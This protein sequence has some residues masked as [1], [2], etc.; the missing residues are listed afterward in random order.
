MPLKSISGTFFTSFVYNGIMMS[1]K[2]CGLDHIPLKNSNFSLLK[3]EYPKEFSCKMLPNN[4]PNMS[5]YS[6][7]S[8]L[9][10]IKTLEFA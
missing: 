9:N 2:L 7:V 4:S 6:V 10:F 1:Y 5:C 3:R 8:I